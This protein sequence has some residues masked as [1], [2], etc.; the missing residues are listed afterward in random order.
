MISRIV[1]KSRVNSAVPLT[2]IYGTTR[3]CFAVT[4]ICYIAR[5]THCSMFS[6]RFM[7]FLGRSWKVEDVY[8]LFVPQW[9]HSICYEVLFSDDSSSSDPR[10][11]EIIYILTDGCS[12]QT[13]SRKNAFGIGKLCDGS[14]FPDPKHFVLTY[15]PTASFKCCCDSS[16]VIMGFIYHYTTSRFSIIINYCGFS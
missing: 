1:S 10:P 12:E 9:K 2:L 15:A 4:E 11:L 14:V 3:S 8:K 7:A 5:W 13:I 16:G 6:K